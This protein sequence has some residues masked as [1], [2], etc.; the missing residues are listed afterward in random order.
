MELVKLTFVFEDYLT[1]SKE[2]SSRGVSS[3]MF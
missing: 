2:D 1:K 3:V